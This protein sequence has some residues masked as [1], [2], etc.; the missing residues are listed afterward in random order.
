LGI[1][2]PNRP[3]ADPGGPVPESIEALS[4]SDVVRRSVAIVDP[5]GADAIAPELLVAFED[6][7]RAAVG[8]GVSLWDELR[9]TAAG[10][11]PEGTSGATAV[12]AAVAF[13]LS[14]QPEGGPDDAATIREAA[15]VA[16]HGDPPAH[17]GAWLADQ[18]L[19]D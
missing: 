13:F 7:D 3:R 14:T 1:Y 17:V 9:T 8:L 12:A 10:L 6:D 11:D 16:W 19:E 4:V 18:G 5:D 2:Y 15:R